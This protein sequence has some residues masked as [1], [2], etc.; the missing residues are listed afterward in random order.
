MIGQ[1]LPDLEPSRPPD[2]R[3]VFALYLGVMA[4]F[5]GLLS[6]GRLGMGWDIP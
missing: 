4:L 3:P 2:Y 6:Y 1:R 5:A